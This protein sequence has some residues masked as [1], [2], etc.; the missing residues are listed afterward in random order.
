MKNNFIFALPIQIFVAG[1]LVKFLFSKISKI[2][3]SN[4]ELA[5]QQEVL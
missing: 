1:P 2:N 5:N 4:L 3:T